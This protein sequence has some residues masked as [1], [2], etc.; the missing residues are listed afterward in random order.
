MQNPQPHSPQTSTTSATEQDTDQAR[1]TELETRLLFMEDTVDKLNEELAT[2][3]HDFL[4]ARQAMQLM[5]KRIE[6]LSKQDG[7]MQLG[8]E[9]P[10]PHY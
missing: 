2:L 1:I 9:P 3:S 8:D 4:L 10:P 6:Q 5:N 7:P